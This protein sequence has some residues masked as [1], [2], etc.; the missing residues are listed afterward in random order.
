MNP[1]E[2]D[3]VL[4]CDVMQEYLKENLKDIQATSILEMAILSIVTRYNKKVKEVKK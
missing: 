2:I 4:F 3:Q 1:K